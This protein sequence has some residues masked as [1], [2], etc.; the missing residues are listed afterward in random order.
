MLH[1]AQAQYLFLIFLIPF[2]FLV[3]WIMLSARK[4]RVAKFGDKELV[5]RLTPDRSTKKGW[6]KLLFYSLA[7]FFFVI[8][9]SRPQIGAALKKQEVS[10]A[11]IMI[12]L[13][14][15]NSMLA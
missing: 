15:S 2:F 13:D 8:G 1:F 11:E 4:R 6:V 5:A 14:V 9:L 3:Y 7:F 12:A 10:G